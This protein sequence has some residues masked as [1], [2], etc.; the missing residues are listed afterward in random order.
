MKWKCFKAYIYV[1][2]TIQNKIKIV[3]LKKKTSNLTETCYNT[4]GRRSHWTGKG[5]QD[6][7]TVY[8]VAN[9]ILQKTGSLTTMKLQKLCYYAQAWA[10]AWDE[11]PLFNEEFEA[12]A[13]GPVCP[14]LFNEHR[15]IFVVNPDFF[16]QKAVGSFTDSEKETMDKVVEYYGDKSPQW[17]SELTHSE[18]PWKI[19][20]NGLPAGVR[21]N[22]IITKESMQEYY[23]GL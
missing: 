19:A 8:D 9:Y 10:L 21:S 11:M 6:V 4:G 16:S 1:K 12:W 14:Q 23:G 2:K 7:N 17:L 22:E 13:N 18:D 15:G 5:C 3:I 20:R